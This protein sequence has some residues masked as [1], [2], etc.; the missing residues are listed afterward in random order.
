M[1]ENMRRSGND[2]MF[3]SPCMTKVLNVGRVSEK[4]PFLPLSL[5]HQPYFHFIFFSSKGFWS[6]SGELVSSYNLLRM[7]KSFLKFSYGLCIKLFPELCF[8]PE[9]WECHCFPTI[10]ISLFFTTT[11]LGVGYCL[12]IFWGG[13][14]TLDNGGLEGWECSLHKAPQSVHL[15]VD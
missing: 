5:P 13:D 8:S 12:L 9:N 3:P 6:C 10:L 4:G 2:S 14:L 7:L 15:S 11:L 1:N